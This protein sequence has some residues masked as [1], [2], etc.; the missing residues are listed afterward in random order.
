M[1]AD[2]LQQLRNRLTGTGN[3]D[4]MVDAKGS[5]SGRTAAL[6]E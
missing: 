4:R 1:T 3:D 6:T 5:L 2:N